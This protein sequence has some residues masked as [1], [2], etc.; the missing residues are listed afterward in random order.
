MA[1][2]ASIEVKIRLYN[3]YI[4]IFYSDSQQSQNT[5]N[6]NREIGGNLIYFL[7]MVRANND[8][9]NQEITRKKNTLN[10]LSRNQQS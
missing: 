8:K 9:E 5:N 2:L 7:L 10:D 6:T 3:F 1:N 4:D